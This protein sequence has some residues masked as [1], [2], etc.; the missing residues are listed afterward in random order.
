MPYQIVNFVNNGV[1]YNIF[2]LA[3][4]KNDLECI[5]TLLQVDHVHLVALEHHLVLKRTL[6]AR[7]E[8]VCD[9]ITS[10]HSEGEVVQTVRR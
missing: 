6:H 2:A 7:L 4:V 5:H 9:L 1:K 3:L 10:I 8:H